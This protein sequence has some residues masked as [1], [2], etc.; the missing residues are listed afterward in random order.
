M[1]ERQALNF[2]IAFKGRF[3]EDKPVK[4]PKDST[5]VEGKKVMKSVRRSRKHNSKNSERPL[6]W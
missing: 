6:G 3:E 1:Q 2:G 4:E 5:E